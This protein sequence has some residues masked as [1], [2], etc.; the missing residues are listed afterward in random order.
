MMSTIEWQDDATLI[1]KH[2]DESSKLGFIARDVQTDKIGFYLY[3]ASHTLQ[4]SGV[5]FR[6]FEFQS[7]EEARELAHQLPITIL[8][9]KAWLKS[10]AKVREISPEPVDDK[11]WDSLKNPNV[12][13]F[14]ANSFMG[15][16]S[17]VDCAFIFCQ[18]NVPLIAVSLPHKT[19]KSISSF[20]FRNVEILEGTLDQKKLNETRDSNEGEA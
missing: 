4:E 5:P 8:I 6:A 16:F 13:K 11:V 12:Q 20:V 17:D 3:D 7:R 10:I 2:E 15:A 9:H 18:H 1:Q 19:A 14:Y